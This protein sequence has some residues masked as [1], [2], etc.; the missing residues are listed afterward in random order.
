MSPKWIIFLVMAWVILALLGGVIEMEYV[1]DREQA[2]LNTLMNAPMLSSTTLWGKVVG[3]FTDWA[4]FGALMKML[5]FDFAMF[6]G[7]WE[8]FRWI[9]FL[10]I[11]IAFIVSLVLAMFRGVGSS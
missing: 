3:M 7:I 6:T 4:W 1:G 5:L 11:S 2:S 9:F 10:P 8:I